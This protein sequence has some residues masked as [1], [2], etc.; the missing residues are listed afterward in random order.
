LGRARRYVFPPGPLFSSNL[1]AI[2]DWCEASYLAGEDRAATVRQTQTYMADAIATVAQHILNASERVTEAIQRQGCDLDSVDATLQLVE[3][4][5][6]YHRAH[7]AQAATLLQL[8]RCPPALP[9]GPVLTPLPASSSQLHDA[10]RSP[11]GKLDLTLL[12]GVGDLGENVRVRVSLDLDA[13]G[14]HSFGMG[15]LCHASVP[16][17]PPPRGAPPPPAAEPPPAT[18]MARA[19]VRPSPPAAR[20]APPP[21]LGAPP[22]LPSS[23]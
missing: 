5:L 19:A 16:P 23:R 18:S 21:P 9:A 15:G 7:I 20:K 8:F 14:R 2:A 13:A 10:L 3:S 12:D 22:P 1:E 11:D 6:A 4:R 17:P